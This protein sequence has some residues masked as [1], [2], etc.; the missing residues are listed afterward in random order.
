MSNDCKNFSIETTWNASDTIYKESA[1]AAGRTRLGTTAS[2]VE[3]FDNSVVYVKNIEAGASTGELT[4]T[5]TDG[6]QKT[7]TVPA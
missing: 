4:I 3:Y 1:N 7:V 6:T 5:F 2:L